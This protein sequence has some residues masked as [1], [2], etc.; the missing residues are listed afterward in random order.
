MAAKIPNCEF[1]MFTHCGHWSQFEKADAFNALVL[2][3]LQR[4]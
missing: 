2:N 4:P 3:F 1:H